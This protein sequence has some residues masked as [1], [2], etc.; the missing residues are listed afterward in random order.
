MLT[1]WDPGARR[2]KVRPPPAPKIGGEYIF[3][4]REAGAEKAV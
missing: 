4:R 2:P 3:F 1:K